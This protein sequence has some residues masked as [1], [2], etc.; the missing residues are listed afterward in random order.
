MEYVQELRKLVG[1]RPLILVGAAV[2]VMNS[3][4]KILLQQ[5][6]DGDWGLPG[7]LMEL[8]ESLEDTARRE[9]KEET[10]IN[11]GKLRLLQ[12]F[13]GP[14]F[15]IR[16]SNGDEFYAV[17]GVFLSREVTGGSLRAD[18]EESLQVAY[19]HLEDLPDNVKENYQTFL[20]PYMRQLMT[21][22]I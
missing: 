21:K 14:E 15:F 4:N 16:V 6:P 1:T 9:V 7:G 20:R 8:G 5:R 17:T 12:V 3:D 18:G 22:Q 19:F 10:G 2:I 11:I 13:S